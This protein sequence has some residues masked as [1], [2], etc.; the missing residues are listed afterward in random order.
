M[1]AEPALRKQYTFNLA[2]RKAYE[3][4]HKE[5][6]LSSHAA[7]I[8]SGGRVLSVACNKPKQ[9]KFILKHAHHDACNMHAE[10]AAILKVKNKES[11]RGSS[12]FV[13]RIRKDSDKAG[14]SRPCEMC[15]SVIKLYGIKKV[16]YSGHNGE[17]IVER[18]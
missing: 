2:L 3:N 5:D 7:I 18:F 1:E 8:V 14:M 12:M 9:N 10:C 4:E 16:Y 13:V 15:Q 6:L 17:I 11:L